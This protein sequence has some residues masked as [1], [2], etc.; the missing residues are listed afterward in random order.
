MIW[1][2]QS[3]AFKESETPKTYN[4]QLGAWKETEG[5]VYSPALKAWEKVWPDDRELIIFENGEWK[6]LPGNW[7]NKESGGTISLRVEDGLLRVQGGDNSANW[8]VQDTAM[9][10]SAY[11]KLY[12]DTTYI[13]CP[14]S[15]ACIAPLIKGGAGYRIAYW[16]HNEM[17]GEL[18][19]PFEDFEGY[20]IWDN[21][22]ANFGFF[23]NWNYYM[24]V[25][26]I[27]FRP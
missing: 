21:K 9:D 23:I 15:Y 25:R 11:T 5:L 20:Y 12:I 27:S 10:L 3:Q 18:E 16:L 17:T 2:S 14:P 7:V 19:I 13:S 22:N 6:N 1:D 26:K 8:I 4:P 24:L